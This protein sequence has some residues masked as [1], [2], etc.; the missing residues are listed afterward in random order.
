MFLKEIKHRAGILVVFQ[1]QK[2][3]VKLQYNYTPIYII[4]GGHK[5]FPFH[6]FHDYA[7]SAVCFDFY[8][9]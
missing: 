4:F 1:Q 9:L 6:T 2:T 3:T 7:L 5:D 8:P